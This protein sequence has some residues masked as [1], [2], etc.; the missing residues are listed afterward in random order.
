VNVYLYGDNGYVITD[1]LHVRKF[2]EKR[3]AIN[4]QKSSFYESDISFYIDIYGGIIIPTAAVLAIIIVSAIV[5]H[6]I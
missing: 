1:G 6:V 5:F 2:G 3:I 4:S